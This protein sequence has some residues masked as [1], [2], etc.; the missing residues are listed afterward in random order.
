M[1][2]SRDSNGLKII[3]NRED[4]HS[5]TFVSTKGDMQGDNSHI[6]LKKIGKPPIMKKYLIT[7]LLVIILTAF[8]Y[9]SYWFVMLKLYQ[10]I[11]FEFSEGHYSMDILE[12]LSIIR[13]EITDL[14]LLKE[15]YINRIDSGSNDT[16]MNNTFQSIKIRLNYLDISMSRKFSSKVDFDLDYKIFEKSSANNEIGPY[17]LIFLMLKFANEVIVDPLSPNFN[18]FLIQYAKLYDNF[19]NFG[20]GSYFDNNLE[21]QFILETKKIVLYLYFGSLILFFGLAISRV[22]YH[23]EIYSVKSQ[24]FESI[25]KLTVAN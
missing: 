15:G 24:I 19:V 9:F 10:R 3:Q 21:N 5:L 20:S 11:I 23:I 6:I 4:K 17:T 25:T 12:D 16:F 13:G 8:M 22:C 7:F 1:F 18:K 14:R 2:N